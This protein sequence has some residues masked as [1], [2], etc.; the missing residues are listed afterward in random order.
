[1][2]KQEG[3]YIL[4]AHLPKINTIKDKETVDLAEFF[5]VKYKRDFLISTN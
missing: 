5:G 4:T 1:M 2:V 3:F